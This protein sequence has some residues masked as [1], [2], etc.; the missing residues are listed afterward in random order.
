V[1]SESD[2]FGSPGARDDV[3]EDEKVIEAASREQADMLTEILSRRKRVPGSK[4][5]PR[6]QE[7]TEWEMIRQD[8]NHATLFFQDMAAQ[9]MSLEEL[10][11]YAW[12]R[13]HKRRQ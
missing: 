3:A 5:V 4:P 1:A 11:N 10:V 12:E 6:D 8:P 13:E 7:E 2:V 9:G